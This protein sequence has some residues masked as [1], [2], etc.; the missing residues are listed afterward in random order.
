M[1]HHAL[2]IKDYGECAKSLERVFE[3]LIK[4]DADQLKLLDE[5]IKSN[6]ELF[7]DKN[8]LIESTVLFKCL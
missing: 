2:K 4:S 1:F 7:L 6:F 3:G 5:V 8:R